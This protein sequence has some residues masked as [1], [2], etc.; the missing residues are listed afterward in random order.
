M[1]LTNE[2]KISI[3]LNNIVNVNKNHYNLELS[4][5]QESAVNSPDS[6]LILSLQNQIADQV[7]KKDALE[8]KLKEL[9]NG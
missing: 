6:E 3:I 1:E 4:L 2:E 7:A 5:Y 8:L 9:D